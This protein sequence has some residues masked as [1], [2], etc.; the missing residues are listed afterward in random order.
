MCYFFSITNESNANESFSVARAVSQ[1]AKAKENAHVLVMTQKNT[2]RR[3]D[4]SEAR[5]NSTVRNSHNVRLQAEE[6]ANIGLMAFGTY[7]SASFDGTTLLG[8][9]DAKVTF[10]K[11]SHVILAI[12]E[13]GLLARTAQVSACG[14]YALRNGKTLAIGKHGSLS[15]VDAGN[16][17]Q[18]VS[19]LAKGEHNAKEHGYKV[20]KDGVTLYGIGFGATDWQAKG[21]VY[22]SLA[23]KSKNGT[24]VFVDMETKKNV[25]NAEVRGAHLVADKASVKAGAD[26][27]KAFA[28][29]AVKAAVITGK[30]SAKLKKG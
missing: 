21:G 23:W 3:F 27:V 9:V 4:I 28:G 16:V 1:T 15:I 8:E 30:K 5:K 18:F 13:N 14:K 7:V 25:Y 24:L 12:G 11:E 6:F 20:A 10:A 17:A 22:C 26:A 19:A 2:V 29:K